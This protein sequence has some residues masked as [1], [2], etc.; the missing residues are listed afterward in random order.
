M[1]LEPDAMKIR[2]R[3]HGVRY[4]EEMARAIYIEEAK[5]VLSYIHCFCPG[6]QPD[7][8]KLAQRYFGIDARNG[9]HSWLITLR[10]SPILW[11]DKQIPGIRLL[12]PVAETASM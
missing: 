1:I 11:A 8:R 7:P 3:P 10:A 4:E 5:D 6:R 12:E 2:M 9:W